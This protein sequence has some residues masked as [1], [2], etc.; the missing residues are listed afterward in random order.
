MTA[1]PDNAPWCVLLAPSLPLG[2]ERRWTVADVVRLRA[3][4]NVFRCQSDARQYILELLESGLG[5]ESTV[6]VSGSKAL[7]LQPTSDLYELASRLFME[8]VFFA[9][10][11][12]VICDA[13]GTTVDADAAVVAGSYTIH[14]KILLDGDVPSWNPKDIDIFVPYGHTP[15]ASAVRSAVTTL[16][17]EMMPKLMPRRDCIID[18]VI[19]EGEQDEYHITGA[20]VEKFGETRITATQAAAKTMA[21]YSV[22][23][24]MKIVKFHQGL[25]PMPGRE[26]WDV[27][28]R[29]IALGLVN[30][31]V[32]LPKQPELA[33]VYSARVSNSSSE[34]AGRHAV[35]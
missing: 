17:T 31:C 19:V 33:F 26:W 14:R 9:E 15:L 29:M 22:D 7:W 21:Y 2:A 20:T 13:V 1:N 5:L 3:T 23:E 16:A 32:G 4:C 12:V 24:L 10:L 35:V 34:N 27:Y 25:H 6:H 30:K 18:K 8:R 28:E 11:P